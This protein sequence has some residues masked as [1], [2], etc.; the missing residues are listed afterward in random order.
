MRD[1]DDDIEPGDVL[2]ATVTDVGWTA[3]FGGVGAVVTDV[4]GLHSHAAIIAREF[5]IPCVVGTERATLDLTDGQMIEVD[6]SSGT[7][8]PVN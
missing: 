5:G 6:G 1:P 3:L 8:K 4:G 2:V 7:V